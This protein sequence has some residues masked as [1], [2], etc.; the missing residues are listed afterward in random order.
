MCVKITDKNNEEEIIAVISE[1]VKEIRVITIDFS[2]AT[3]DSF[4][5]NKEYIV[6]IDI[7]L[8]ATGILILTWKATIQAIRKNVEVIFKIEKFL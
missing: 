1:I 5:Y 6:P 7:I 3:L 8:N 4:P 2:N